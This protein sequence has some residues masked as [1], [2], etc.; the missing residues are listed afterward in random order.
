MYILYYVYRQNQKKENNR[1]SDCENFVNQEL[2]NY[3]SNDILERD[4]IFGGISIFLKRLKDFAYALGHA[5]GHAS[6]LERLWQQHRKDYD[7]RKK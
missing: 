3:V 2:R 7:G 1:I 6:D 5:S 4:L